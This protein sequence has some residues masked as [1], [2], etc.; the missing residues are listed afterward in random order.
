MNAS[1][2]SVNEEGATKASTSNVFPSSNPTQSQR[3]R[4]T[5]KALTVSSSNQVMHSDQIFVLFTDRSQICHFPCV[6]T[7]GTNEES[8][9]N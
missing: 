3:I 1:V 5:K 9:L 7:M 2:V 4:A 6:C 8:D